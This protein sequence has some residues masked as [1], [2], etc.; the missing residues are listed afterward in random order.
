MES[1]TPSFIP[2]TLERGRTHDMRIAVIY[3]QLYT[4][5]L[6]RGGNQDMRNAV[7][8]YTRSTLTT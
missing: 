2:P 8:Y 1:F 6:A 7:I 4:P 5:T 3:T